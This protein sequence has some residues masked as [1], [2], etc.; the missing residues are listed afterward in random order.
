MATTYQDPPRTH[1]RTGSHPQ[2]LRVEAYIRE[3]LPGAADRISAVLNQLERLLTGDGTIKS[4]TVTKWTAAVP[5]RLSSE[6]LAGPQSTVH[7]TVDEF[8]EW[9]AQQDC[10]LTPAFDWTADDEDE[11]EDRN[12]RERLRVPI[13]G[14]AVY[15][16]G[17][18]DSDDTE[19]GDESDKSE[20]DD[21]LVV[22]PYTD[23]D[24]EV[25][26]IEDGLT[27]LEEA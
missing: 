13:I 26:T 12:E 8:R 20:D 21:L 4:V 18:S 3:D 15:E 23:R 19:D 11:N 22:F 2:G 9:A 10:S 27:T 16:T 14:L 7:N 24:G 25:Q 1:L 17:P 5:D 6:S